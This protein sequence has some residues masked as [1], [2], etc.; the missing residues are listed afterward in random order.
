MAK[1]GP[2]PP[3][4]LSTIKRKRAF[5]TNARTTFALLLLVSLLVVAVLVK[6][7]EKP[8][9]P[10]GEKLEKLVS[11]VLARLSLEAALLSWE[12]LE[13]SSPTLVV[14]VEAPEAFPVDRLAL[15]LEAA[16]HNLGGTLEKL[17]VL[18]KGGYAQAAFRGRLG[19]AQLRVLLMGAFV[20]QAPKKSLLTPRLVGEKLGRLAVVLDDAGYS[21]DVLPLIAQLP[22]EVAVAVLPNAPH[23]AAIAQKLRSEGRELLLHMPMEP[24]GNGASPG[25]GAIRVGLDEKEV[26][27]RLEEAL[28]VV[29]PVAGLNNHM[30]SRATADPQL[31]KAFMQA[32]RGRRLYFLDSRTTGASVAAEVAQQAGIPTLSRDVFL[33]VVEEEAAIRSALATAAALARSR[34]FAVTIGH[35]H[36]LTLKVLKRELPSLRGVRLVRPSQIAEKSGS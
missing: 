25:E 28:E 4:R 31:M 18:E 24:G 35:V 27:R 20:E 14:V 11:Q 9:F 13:G 22:R 33:D 10:D 36:P 3:R 21:E 23:T 16:L 30:G 15:D 2:R 34:G 1:K 12:H 8:A 19:E 29:G 26:R 17:P 5:K 6:R 32:L 7:A